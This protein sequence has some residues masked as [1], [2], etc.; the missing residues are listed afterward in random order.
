MNKRTHFSKYKLSCVFVTEVGSFS[1]DILHW[2]KYVKEYYEIQKSYLYVPLFGTN[3]ED[4]FLVLAG[5]TARDCT[6][7]RQDSSSYSRMVWKF[8]VYIF[9]SL[10]WE[11]ISVYLDS[12]YVISLNNNQKYSSKQNFKIFQNDQLFTI[13]QRPL[14]LVSR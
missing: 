9:L 8:L 3:T 13:I 11:E 12:I 4:K 6:T 7:N 2:L 1:E 10:T 14:L 5:W